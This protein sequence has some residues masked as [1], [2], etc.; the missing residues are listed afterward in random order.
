MKK[1]EFRKFLPHLSAVVIFF[2]ISLIYFFPVIEGYRLKQGDIQKHKAMAHE[3]MSHQEKYGERILWS[4]NMFGGMPTYMTSTVKYN[5]N[6]SAILLKVFKGGLPHPASA[7]FAY[8]LGFFILLCC[9]KINPW[10]SIIGSIA[11]AFS[12]Y[13]FIIIE[14]GHTSKIYAISM[15]APILGGFI[16]TIRGNWKIGVLLIALFTSMQLYVNHL[17]ITYYLFMILVF[18]GFGELI[19]YLREKQHIY[20]LKRIGLVLSAALIGVLPSLGNL[21]IAAEYSAESTRGK[22][23]LTIQPNGESNESIVS[24]GLDKD[25]ITDWS[26]G[27]DETLTLIIPNAKGG[28]SVPIIGRSDEIERLRKEDPRFLNLLDSEYRNNRNLV[29]SYFGNQPIVSG[30]VYAGILI[31]FIA[32]LALFTLKNRLLTS[33]VAITILTIMLAWGRNFMGLTEFFIDYVPGYNKFRAVAMI[34]LVSELTLPIMAIIFLQKLIEDK[35]YFKQ[36]QRKLAIVTGV[37]VAFLGI[38]YLSPSTF[39][40]L[41]SDSEQ[42]RLTQQINSGNNQAIEVHSQ[43]EAYREDVVSASAGRSLFILLC[44]AAILFLFLQGKVKYKVMLT[45]LGVLILADMWSINKEYVNNKKGE[46]RRVKYE[47]WVKQAEFSVPYEPSFG[48][49]QILNTEAQLNGQLNQNIQARINEVKSESR[50]N[51]DQRK[52][53]DIT[54]A[55]LM[56]L[57][58]YRVLNTQSR[59]DQDVKT[60]Y[61]HKSL[62][63]YHGAK[64]KKYQELIDFYLGI[65][66]YQLRQSFIQ[67]GIQM[68]NAMLPSMKVTNLMNT[69]YII[70]PDNSGKQ[71]ELVVKNPYAYGNAWFVSSLKVVAN[72]DSA[73]MA[74]RNTDLRTTA[75]IE[76]KDASHLTQHEYPNSKLSSIKLLEYSPVELK[77]TYTADSDQYIVFSEIYYTPGWNVYVNG[78]KSSFEKVNYIFRGM[79]LPQGEGEIVFKFEPQTYE[80]GKTLTWASTILMLLLIGFVGY[81]EFKKD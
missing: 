12:S 19:F 26:Y 61:F 58:H 32:F 46:T 9:L 28:S 7:V 33:L 51:F 54:Y 67:G 3:L 14:A 10:L 56:E 27:I 6:I 8:M 42:Q 39:I 23:S 59:L 11:F 55:E 37:F 60:P 1:I 4:G 25:Y 64:L 66:H 24:S 70:G 5:G 31:A 20:F 71:P 47:N 79:A 73:I 29:I 17:Q 30:P 15:M 50:S 53:I 2:A 48:D 22:S 72:A 57:T 65:E 69:K 13:F 18:V 75:I 43:I 80:V 34:L 36:Q 74:I 52:I 44:G 77:Y 41:S 45:A 81:S 76:E 78:E 49:Q 40:G 62:G 68:V 16:Q 35:L 21:M 38:T 63:G